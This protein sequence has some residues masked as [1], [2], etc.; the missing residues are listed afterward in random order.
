MIT[1]WESYFIHF[2]PVQPSYSTVQHIVWQRP[3]YFGLLQAIWLILILVSQLWL[4]MAFLLAKF[5]LF[6]I[7]F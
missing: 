1:K 2:S 3:P 4:I 6:K 5:G 7:I